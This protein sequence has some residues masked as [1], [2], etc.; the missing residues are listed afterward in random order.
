MTDPLLI[1]QR[2]NA[3]S[4]AS[5]M[6]ARIAFP[7]LFRHPLQSASQAHGMHKRGSRQETYQTEN[8]AH[9]EIPLFHS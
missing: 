7:F 2:A 9:Y 1:L 8:A 6:P 3:F 4:T 5:D